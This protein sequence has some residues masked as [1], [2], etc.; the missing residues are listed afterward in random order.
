MGWLG[1]PEPLARL[2]G[3]SIQLSCPGALPGPPEAGSQTAQPFPVGH[4]G[5]T[6]I[7]CGANGEPPA[8]CGG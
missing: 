7:A 3:V 4:P 1:N 8:A 2:A 5:A 6:G